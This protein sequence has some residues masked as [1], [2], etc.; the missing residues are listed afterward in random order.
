M[1]IVNK[2]HTPKISVVTLGCSKNTVDSEVLLAQLIGGKAHIV[3]DVDDADIAVINTCGFIEAAKQESIDAI[4]EAVE[5]KKQGRLKKVVVMGCLS[6]RFAKDLAAE[7]PNVDAYF[8]SHHL[9]QVVKELGIDYREEL[10]GERQLTT[11]SHY[12]Y[13]KISEGCDNPCSFCAIPLMRGLHVSKPLEQLTSEV[14]H[15]AARGVKELILIGQDTTYYGLDLSGERQLHRLLR[16]IVD[17]EGPE[18]IRLMYAFPTKFPRNILEVYRET[19]KLCR[20]LDIPIQHVSDNVLKSMRRGMTN[21]A[22]RELLHGIKESVPGIG[23]RSTLIVGYPTE[24]DDDFNML[25]DFVGEMKFHRLGV[26]TYSQE[27]GTFAYDLGDPIPNEIKEER[28]SRIMEL[29][30]QISEE[31]NESLVGTVARVLIDRREGEFFVGRTE[32]DAPE[33][34]QE[35]FVRA[36]AGVEV[37]SFIDVKVTHFTEYDLY[38]EPV[39]VRSHRAARNASMMEGVG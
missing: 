6:E 26:F 32:W 2:N 30:Q 31:R 1:R 14:R 7:I 15:L 4:L 10:L 38:A 25:L 33:I 8:G 11:P 19:P 5:R 16:E 21:R 28:R 37:G 13:L 27:E 24:T 39:P 18:W 20:Y 29:Q 3:D 34:D 17:I 12:A 22:M 9:A 35:V 23:I 36:S